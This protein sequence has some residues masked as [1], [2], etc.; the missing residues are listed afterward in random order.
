MGGR[1]GRAESDAVVTLPPPTLGNGNDNGL[2]N[3]LGSGGGSGSSND[4]DNGLGEGLERRDVLRRASGLGLGWAVSSPGAGR[5]KA[6]AGRSMRMAGRRVAIDEQ[7]DILMRGTRFADEAEGWQGEATEAQGLRAQMRAELKAKLE[8]GRPLRVYLGVDPTSTE[9][10]VGHF[11][12][13]QRL[14]RF[15]E[16]DHQVVFLI[17]DY[18]ATIGD[19]SGQS[20]ERRRFAHAEVLEMARTYTEQAFRVLDPERTEVRH[21]GEWLAKLSFADLI[22]L[23][24]IFPLKQVIARRDFRERMERGESLR[25]HEAL[26]SLMQGYDAFALECDVQVGAYD[27]HF[28]MLA[29]RAIQEHFGQAPHVML[30]NPLIIG[31]DGRKMSKSFGN[32]I[33][34]NDQPFDM[35]GKAMRVADEHIQEYLELTTSLAGGE[36]DQLVE[37]LRS[38][39]NPMEVKKRLAA[40]LVEQYHG[41]AAV[42]EAAETF[43]QVV[44]RKEAPDDVSEVEVPAALAG[45]TWVDL[46]VALGLSP[47]KGELRRLMTQG[48]FYV[49]QEPVR[50]PHA[51]AR[52]PDGGVLIRLGKRRYFR[53]APGK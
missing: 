1:L 52:V 4:N 51:P 50:D 29:G 24:S 44:Q 14:R 8:L 27:Q 2:G 34:V 7:L 43:Q 3:G 22:E 5:G 16:L 9:L 21:N 49:E 35:Y 38:G 19:P 42:A 41:P 45:S 33:N 28:N 31:T 15:Q 53:L 12:P 30:T 39:A 47:S 11:V 26:Y 40:N 37:R 20:S 6:G 17:G 32:T 48:G 36:I 10:H 25:F 18:T 23:A 46:C 13:L